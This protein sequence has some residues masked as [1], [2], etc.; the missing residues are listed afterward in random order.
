MIS[1]HKLSFE[2]I[3]DK[4]W[5]NLDKKLQIDVSKYRRVRRDV[6]KF[7]K[8]IEKQRELIKEKQF[9]LRK[10]NKILTHLYSK[11][12]HLKSDFLPIINVVSYSKKDNIY[13]NINVKF[14]N[15]VK[16]NYL[17][18]DNKVRK[19]FKDRIGLRKNISNSKLKRQIGDLL[20]TCSDQSELKEINIWLKNPTKSVSFSNYNFIAIEGNIGAGKTSLATKI[21]YDFNA[22][23]V[24]ERFADNAFLPKFYEDPQRYAF[25]LEMSF[26]ADRYQQIT[27]DLS[28]L[29]LFKDF[30]VSDYDVFKSLIFSKITLLEDE[31]VLYRKLFYLMYKDIA[32]PDLYVY[33][34]QNTRRL[35]ENIKKRGR[36]YEQNIEDNYLEK[37]N[38]GYLEFLKN[39]TDIKVKI[40][41]I[42][43]LDFV[44][45]RVDY[46]WLLNQICEDDVSG[47]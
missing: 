1:K 35:Q 41:D 9:K 7:E 39:Q 27:D 26:L 17:G 37:I 43:D 40:I 3:S 4:V 47:D 25:P 24:L 22:K 11:I 30:V 10:Y 21:S 32:K 8:E 31:F 14:Q 44:K 15:K 33:L 2:G 19:E 23:L 18:S 12:N 45:N 46:L 42:S 36:D 5:E 16:S 38:S 29:D 13:W 6:I 20:K 34:Y 28:Q